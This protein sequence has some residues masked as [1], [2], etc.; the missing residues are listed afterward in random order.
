LLHGVG[1]HGLCW[2]PV[3]NLLAAGGFRPLALDMRG[4]GASGRAPGLGYGWQLF[5]ADILAVVDG[6][7]LADGDGA[8]VGVGHSAGASALLLAEAGRP[9]SFSRIWAWEPIVAVAGSSLRKQR[10]SEL[11]QRAR[12]RRSHFPSVD[13]ARA[14]LKGRGMF[15]EFCPDAFEAFLAGGLV[16]ADEG[17]V[18]LACRAEDEAR[19]YAAAAEPRSWARLEAVRCPVAVRGGETSPAVPRAELEAI[20]AQL[21]AGEPEVVPSLGHFGPFQGPTDVAANIAGWA[22]GGPP[23]PGA[24]PQPGRAA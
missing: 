21:P 18:K 11:A 20:A 13:E 8:L 4:H 3:A 17:G 10:S 12:R 23:G 22:R 5:A 14:H 15:A 7:G 1:L 24:G 9:G 19:A 2:G 16:P 6:L